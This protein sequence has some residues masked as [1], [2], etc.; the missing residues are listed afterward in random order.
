MTADQII[1]S[2]GQ[3]GAD[4][5]AIAAEVLSN[6][7]TIPALLEGLEGKT[8]NLRYGTEK[9]LRLVSEK[10]PE[11]IYPHFDR[12]VE[13]MEGDNK[14]LEWGAIMTIANLAAVDLEGRVDFLVGS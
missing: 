10:R 2:L 4:R 9:V 14:F 1:E 3:K 12:F 7:Q 6:P 13:L 11:F 5:E 8:A